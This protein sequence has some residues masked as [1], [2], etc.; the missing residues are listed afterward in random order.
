MKRK[1]DNQDSNVILSSIYS[2]AV[3]NHEVIKQNL[4]RAKQGNNIA[5][6]SVSFIN[7]IMKFK[8]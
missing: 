8:M 1:R 5:M 3:W 7:F 2:N 6:E 4:I